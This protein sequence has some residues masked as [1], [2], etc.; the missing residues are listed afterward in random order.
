MTQTVKAVY[1]H[2]VHIRDATPDDATAVFQLASQLHAAFVIDSACFAASY[3]HALQDDQHCC[4]VAVLNGQTIGYAS[5]YRHIAF[6]AN[7]PVADLDEIVVAPRLR[8]VGIGTQLVAAFEAWA[9]DNQCRPVSLATAGARG[10]YDKCGSAS[11]ARDYKKY[12]S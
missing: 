7:G 12:R 3:R 8:G 6:Y 1:E 9:H 10:V 5:G 2:D 11:T 4:V